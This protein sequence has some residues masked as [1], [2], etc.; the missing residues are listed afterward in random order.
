MSKSVFTAFLLICLFNALNGRNLI[1][2]TFDKTDE[3]N[4][5]INGDANDLIDR[6]DASRLNQILNEYF[7][8]KENENLL[9][10]KR[11]PKRWNGRVNA[12]FLNKLID[13]DE[14]KPYYS[15]MWEGHMKEKN[16]M[17]QNVFG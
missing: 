15:K 12:K 3:V 11:F 17:Y 6:E 7:L 16:K 10:D 14:F 2:D 5:V 13:N 1:K 4:L 9:M 8:L